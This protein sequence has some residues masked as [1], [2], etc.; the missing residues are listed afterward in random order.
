MRAAVADD[1]MGARIVQRIAV[2]AR[3]KY[4]DASTTSGEISTTST[5]RTG[6]TSADASVTP[7]PSPIMPTLRGILVQQ[8]RQMGQQPSASACRRVF[9]ASIFPSMASVEVPVSRLT[10]T[11]DAAPSR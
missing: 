8:Q 2:L 3:E 7:L 11:V 6:C 4:R 10:D 1:Q 5:P 9:D